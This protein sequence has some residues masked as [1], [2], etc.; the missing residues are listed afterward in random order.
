MDPIT[1][2]ILAAVGAAATSVAVISWRAVQKWI[3]AHRVPN[4]TA[5]IVREKLRNGNYRVVSGVFDNKG[6]LRSQKTWEAERLD[7][8]LD[9]EF[10]RSN[11]TIVV[12]F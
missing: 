4:G 9:G 8:D 11:G 3:N 5:R 1:L 2:L 10:R 6:D 7:E 12:R